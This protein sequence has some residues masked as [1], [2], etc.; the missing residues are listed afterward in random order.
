M[1]PA[2]WN[3]LTT[4]L[5]PYKQ[6]TNCCIQTSCWGCSEKGWVGG[7]HRVRAGAWVAGGHRQP[8]PRRHKPTAPER[9]VWGWADSSQGSRGS[10]SPDK[11]IARGQAWGPPQST[12]RARRVRLRSWQRPSCPLCPCLLQQS[13]LLDAPCQLQKSGEQ[14]GPSSEI[15][16]PQ[17]SGTLKNCFRCQTTE[18]STY[19]LSAN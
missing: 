4:S 1:F 14:H 18:I 5:L 19:I 16:L 17:E 2:D 8:S 13:A 9:A 3:A 11:T 15:L 6:E 7:G 10:G 12:A